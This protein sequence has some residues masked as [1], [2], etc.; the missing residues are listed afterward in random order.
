L[1][2]YS[3]VFGREVFDG[4]SRPR[5]GG[6]TRD[7][8]KRTGPLRRMSFGIWRNEID[9]FIAYRGL[10]VRRVLGIGR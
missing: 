6:K 5:G 8:I 9:N 3:V 4:H 10:G 1:R 7:R 2:F